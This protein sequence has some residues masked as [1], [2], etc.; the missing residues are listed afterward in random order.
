MNLVWINNASYLGDY[1]LL[2]HFSNGEERI[3]DAEGYIS[4]H[5]LFSSLKDTQLFRHFQLD[6]WTVSWLDGKLDIAPEFL[7]D[8]GMAVERGKGKSEK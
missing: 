5:P 1:R 3:Y 2:L 7:Y 4:T 6:G 8:A